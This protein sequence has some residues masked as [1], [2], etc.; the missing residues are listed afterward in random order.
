MKK[1][2]KKLANL[3]SQVVELQKEEK[4]EEAIEKQEEI[5]ALIK[6]MSTS[7]E[8]QEE[9]GEKKKEEEIEKA[10]LKK[11]EEEKEK[12]QKAVEE[13]NKWVN[14]DISA[15]TITDLIKQFNEIKGQMTK[16]SKDVT[17][18]LD[19]IEKAEGI[20]TQGKE[21]VEKSKGSIFSGVFLEKGEN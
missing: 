4:F 13:I 21:P 5:Q 14:L 1:S 15:D 20:S 6:E 18:R 8:K 7:I 10:K 16:D 17:D 9:K 19:K 2:L 11:E 12:L 3:E